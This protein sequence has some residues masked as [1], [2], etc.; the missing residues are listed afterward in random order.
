MISL[1]CV[2]DDPDIHMLYKQVLGTRDYHVRVYGNGTEA[3]TAFLR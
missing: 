3:V 2:D 1:M